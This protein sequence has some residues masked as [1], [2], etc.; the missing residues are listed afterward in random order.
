MWR[1]NERS[2]NRVVCGVELSASNSNIVFGWTFR[3]LYSDEKK[4]EEEE[5]RDGQQPQVLLGFA[6]S[7][8]A[9]STWFESPHLDGQVEEYYSRHV[10]AEENHG[11]KPRP[12]PHPAMLS[13]RGA[14]DLGR[15]GGFAAQ[16]RPHLLPRSHLDLAGAAEAEEER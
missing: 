11:G 13:G 14:S 16:P 1:R 10:S 7:P 15:P 4:K 8:G 6:S 9:P 5:E 12:L 2:I 3:V